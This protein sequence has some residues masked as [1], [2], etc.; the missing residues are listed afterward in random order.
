MFKLPASLHISYPTILALS[1]ELCASIL[2]LILLFL[3]ST[4]SYLCVHSLKQEAFSGILPIYHFIYVCVRSVTHNPLQPH[5]LYSPLGSSGHGIFQARILE[6]VAISYSRE[7]SQPP[8]TEPR[9]LA[10]LALAGR[11]FTTAPYK[12]IQ[13]IQTA[14]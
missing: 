10:S 5:G 1:Q 3:L 7:S 11:F 14:L 6:Q 12:H 8:D 9:S 4:K 2:H 13:P